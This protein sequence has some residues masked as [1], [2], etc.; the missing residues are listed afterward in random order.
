MKLA[1]QAIASM[2]LLASVVNSK[3]EDILLQCR[4]GPDD[5]KFAINDKR[6]IADGV[7]Q[8]SSDAKPIEIGSSYI[9]FYLN[10]PNKKAYR[11][12]IDRGTGKLTLSCVD[13]ESQ[14][15]CNNT[16]GYCE[17]AEVDEKKF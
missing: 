13:N 15:K 1:V 9:S 7:I 6:I 5:V 8:P 16:Q 3:A 14:I 12:V 17:K 11:A 4:L 10:T 2:L